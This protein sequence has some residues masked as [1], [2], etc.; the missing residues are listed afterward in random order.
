M[1]EEIL[2]DN[3]HGSS[4]LLNKTVDFL[5]DKPIETQ[6]HYARIIAEKHK[7]MAYLVN[8]KNFIEKEHKG[9][10]EFTKK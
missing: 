10:L 6:Y 9:C 4:Y 1:L 5:K 2:K 7:G 8:L 3:L